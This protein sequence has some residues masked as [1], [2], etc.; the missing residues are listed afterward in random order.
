MNKEFEMTK[1][2]FKIALSFPGQYRDRV[3]SIAGYLAEKLGRDHIL[4]DKW[5]DAEFARRDLD[6]YLADLYHSHSEL[7]VVF[8]CAEYENSEW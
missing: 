6:I 3:E 2:R 7:L 5:Y 1:S 8:L 4:Y